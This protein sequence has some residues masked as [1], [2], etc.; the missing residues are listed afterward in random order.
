MLYHKTRDILYVKQQLGHR[1]IENTMIYT[2][3][4]TPSKATS[5]TQPTQKHSKKKTNC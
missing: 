2:Q 3:L 5:T 1:N 4:I